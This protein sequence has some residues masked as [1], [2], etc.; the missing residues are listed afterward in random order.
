MSNEESKKYFVSIT[1]FEKQRIPPNTLNIF[2]V[3]HIIINQ[4]I[5]SSGWVGAIIL[6]EKDF[7]EYS[8]KTKL[9]KISECFEY[10]LNES[11]EQNFNKGIEVTLDSLPGGGR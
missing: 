8:N 1:E 5:T 7:Q 3:Q 9:E 4:G 6:G 10:F 2:Y 11:N